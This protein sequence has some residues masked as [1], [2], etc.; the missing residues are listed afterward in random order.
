MNVLCVFHLFYC[1]ITTA[2]LSSNCT[3]KKYPRNWQGFW[4]L[5]LFSLHICP[6]H[7][8]PPAPPPPPLPPPKP[9]KPPPPPPPD[10]PPEPPLPPPPNMEPRIKG[11]IPDP[12]NKP[13]L[14]PPPLEII[15]RTIKIMMII[16][17]IEPPPPT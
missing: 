7:Q 17:R 1:L 8:L 5:F 4:S 15:K 2:K 12:L 14:P 11:R 13:P 10:Q 16:P 9:P 6:F 3:T